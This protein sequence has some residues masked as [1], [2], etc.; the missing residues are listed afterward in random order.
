MARYTMLAVA[1]LIVLLLGTIAFLGGVGQYQ[2]ETSFDDRLADDRSRFDRSAAT[3][4]YDVCAYNNTT[5]ALDCPENPYAG[6]LRWLGGGLLTT[7]V[8]AGLVY[9]DLERLETGPR[10]DG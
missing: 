9:Y 4:G 2:A 10:R 8:G 7:A 5:A 1:G 6:S 3:S